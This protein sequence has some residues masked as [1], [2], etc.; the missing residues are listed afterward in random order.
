MRAAGVRNNPLPLDVLDKD[1]SRESPMR[2]R[3]IA[4]AGVIVA[5]FGATLAV[6]EEETII[7]ER[8]TE[9]GVGVT[10]VP[11]SVTVRPERERDA[12]IERRRTHDRN[13]GIDGTTK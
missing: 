12:T 10:V 2:L 3:T 6:A 4:Y 9:P 7:R 5:T 13:T 1:Q 8:T 11:P